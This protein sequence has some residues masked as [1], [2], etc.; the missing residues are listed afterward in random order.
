[1]A[2][3]L[4]IKRKG[5]WRKAYTTKNG[6]RVKRKYIKPTSY[7]IKN[8]GNPGRTSRGAEAGPYKNKKPWIRREG[9]LGGPGYTK[10]SAAT[11]HA[12]LRK[13]IKKYGY[14]ST[15]GS[16]SVLTEN[17]TIKPSTRRTL[18]ADERWLRKTYRKG[19]K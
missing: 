8:Q 1:M 10:K 12:I 2:K 9:K 19:Q 3:R 6:T 4:L 5:Y 13:S 7:Y 16:V 15:M 11:R 14:A 18:E 17:A